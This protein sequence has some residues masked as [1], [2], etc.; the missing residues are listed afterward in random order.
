MLEGETG[1]CYIGPDRAQTRAALREV[2]ADLPEAEFARLMDDPDRCVHV[3]APAGN[4]FYQVASHRIIV[5]GAATGEKVEVHT[6]WVFLHPFL[7][8][9]SVIETR[10]QVA[11]AFTMAL[12]RLAGH[13]DLAALQLAGS[14][15]AVVPAGG[16]RRPN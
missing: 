3:M 5:T 6:E 16:V 12:A 7:E 4:V 1:R 14:T 8:H 2:L 10:S 15:E 9:L 13:S 11:Q